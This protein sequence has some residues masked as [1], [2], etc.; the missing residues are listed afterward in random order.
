MAQTDMGPEQCDCP[1]VR[2]DDAYC[3]ADLVF[4]GIPFKT[5][6]LMPHELGTPDAPTLGHV[7]IH[8]KTGPVLKGNVDGSVMILTTL[9]PEA[10]TF[11]FLKGTNY[12]VFAHDEEGTLYTD[13]C[14]PTRAM[15]SISPSFL[16]SLE[17]VR[18]G[19]RWE[20]GVPLD[21]PCR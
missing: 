17:Y 19:K 14:S 18:S 21:I 16:D 1:T 2:V 12:L 3:A 7:V 11:R 4:E 20:G 13:R 10:C 6:T 15:D 8:F 9:G 5:D